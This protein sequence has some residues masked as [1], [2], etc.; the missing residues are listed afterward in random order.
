MD[1]TA[2]QYKKC[3]RTASDAENEGAIA[4]KGSE[5]SN[6]SH[7]KG[8]SLKPA[9]RL[10]DLVNVDVA[11]HEKVRLVVANAAR[12]CLLHVFTDR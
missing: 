9:A 5:G 1:E 12:D 6:T 8:S 10:V 7:S 3:K 4:E 11:A 2:L